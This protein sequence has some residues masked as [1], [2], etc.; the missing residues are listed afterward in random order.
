MR[1]VSRGFTLVELLV[2]IAI[3]GML[4]A[5]LTSLSERRREMAI[6]RS[7]GA[8]PLHV[9]ALVLGEAIF[10]TVLG[11]VLGIAVL[12]LGLVSGQAWLESRLGLFIAIGWPSVYEFG[13]I[14]LVGI[15][16]GLIGLVPAW[17]IYSYSLSDGMSIRI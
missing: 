7:V 15:A 2:S 6:L 14:L 8:R 5:L 10:L 4:V 9:F 17:R 16:G 11:I 3:I 1:R 12:Y 13:L